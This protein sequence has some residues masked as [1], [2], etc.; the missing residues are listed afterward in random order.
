MGPKIHLCPE[1]IGH[2][3]LTLFIISIVVE[4]H[5]GSHKSLSE[6]MRP[7]CFTVSP[8]VICC[9]HLRL[10]ESCD[11]ARHRIHPSGGG[12]GIL[13]FGM[14]AFRPFDDTG[15]RRSACDRCR[16]HKLRCERFA[17]SMQCRRCLKASA[18]CVT[19]A[20][21]KSGRPTHLY[22]QDQEP[23]IDQIGG[24]DI[25]QNVRFGSQ[26]VPLAFPTPPPTNLDRLLEDDV[27]VQDTL[28]DMN[29]FRSPSALHNFDATWTDVFEQGLLSPSNGEVE[30]VQN[31]RPSKDNN[32][33]N[34]DGR[35]PSDKN[36]ALM[37]RLGELQT[38]I[39]IDLET[40]KSCSTAGS[41]SN[42]P[43]VL[44]S[45]QTNNYL[46]G[47]MLGNSTTLLEILDCFQPFRP[48]STN[49]SDRGE[50][51]PPSEGDDRPR[52]N[53]PT[54]FTLM[55]SYICLVRIYRTILSCIYD[56]LPFFLGLPGPSF[57]LFPGLD[58]GGFRLATRVDLQ[59]QILLQVSE[60]MLARIEAKFGFPNTGSNGRSAIL[61]P[62]N[63]AKVLG[64][65]LEEEASEQPPLHI[66]RGACAPLR[67]ILT[68]MK[69]AITV[70]SNG[71]KE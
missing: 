52:C 22:L 21:L 26:Q 71:I 5:F 60:D 39:L 18:N 45:G 33:D 58:L 61:D 1:S 2:Q 49:I 13:L 44:E 41:C 32:S 8:H 25:P 50:S 68:E 37:R 34:L 40:V 16:G 59:I 31:N 65:M 27:M 47:Q 64:A 53:A 6:E 12:I 30:S 57:E 63:S 54:M 14:D 4:L 43:E 7:H 29:L 9:Y 24:E 51:T 67:Q 28:I 70:H 23:L 48:A 35:L 19:S 3:L 62:A 36:L 38:K 56:S 10:G 42:T 17:E 20:A 46:I 69:Q 15:N 55:S 11:L 66:Q